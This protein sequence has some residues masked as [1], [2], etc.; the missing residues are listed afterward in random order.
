MLDLLGSLR[1]GFTLSVYTHFAFWFGRHLV[2]SA[3][4]FGSELGIFFLGFSLEYPSSL[5]GLH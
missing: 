3:L 4:H 5:L 1:D 2:S